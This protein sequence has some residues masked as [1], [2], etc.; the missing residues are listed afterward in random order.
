MWFIVGGPNT[1]GIS[2]NGTGNDSETTQ[3][4]MV[5]IS[6]LLQQANMSMGDVSQIAC[7]CLL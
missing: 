3:K 2:H 1:S 5:G 4:G 7:V 6:T